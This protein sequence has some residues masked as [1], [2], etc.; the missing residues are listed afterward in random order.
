M[1]SA[2]IIL[3]PLSRP[4]PMIIVAHLF[5]YL[6]QNDRFI[7]LHAWRGAAVLGF[8]WAARL[9]RQGAYRAASELRRSRIDLLRRPGLCA[10]A[11]QARCTNLSENCD[12]K[13]R[14]AICL[15]TFGCL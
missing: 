11:N 15:G 5:F 6:F 4:E 13:N 2:G 1:A 14:L 3:K 12:E 9:H 8:P 10:P 7:F